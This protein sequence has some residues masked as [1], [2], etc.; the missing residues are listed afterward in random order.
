MSANSDEKTGLMN[1]N[2]INDYFFLIKIVIHV[3]SEFS[4]NPYML[5]RFPFVI[6]KIILTNSDINYF[7]FAKFINFLLHANSIALLSG[8]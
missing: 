6:K 5:Y 1:S 3:L 8:K 2:V 4:E 7:G